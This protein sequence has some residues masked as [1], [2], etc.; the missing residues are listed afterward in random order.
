MMLAYLKP[1]TQKMRSL[2][3]ASGAR[4]WNAHGPPRPTTLCPA[5]ANGAG[6]QALNLDPSSKRKM[7]EFRV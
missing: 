5:A 7:L 3:L 6:G 2:K 1:E 4:R